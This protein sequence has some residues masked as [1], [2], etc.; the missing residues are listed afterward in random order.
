MPAAGLIRQLNACPL[1]AL[2]ALATLLTPAAARA[3]D[4]ACEGWA[5]GERVA[6]IHDERLGES[7]GLA[8]SW[9]NPDILWTHNDSGDQARL[10]ALSTTGEVLTEVRLPPAQNVDWED[11]AIGPCQPGSPQPCLYLADI[12]DNLAR[13]DHLMIYRVPEPRLAE[14]PPPRLELTQDIAAQRFTYQGGPR[15]AEALLVDPR[16]AEIFILEKNDS[17]N[18][19]VFE[20][21]E[22]FAE[23]DSLLE[24][25]H[26]AELTLPGSLSFGKMITAADVSPDGGEFTLRTYT[27]LLTYCAPGGEL[28]QAFEA[29]PQ[30]VMVNPGTLQGE[31]L[32][33]DRRDD[34]LWLTSERLPAPLIRVDRASAPAARPDEDADTAEAPDTTAEPADRPALPDAA[35]VDD[36]T[37]G[38][39]LHSSPDAGCA[40]LASDAP[41]GYGLTHLGVLLAM[42][43]LRLWGRRGADRRTRAHSTRF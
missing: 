26:I 22:A 36:S 32:T 11:M 1:I 34:A 27:H 30:R 3:Q 39:T 33:Y 38:A 29:A 10:F 5:P 9:L 23:A 6:E 37:P 42:A 43:S 8:A 17:G 21:S 31:A 41:G 28:R 13:R 12:G 35:G 7:S 20:L 15:D 2:V 25:R 24:A 14:P 40:T 19:G 18:A 16:S 4:E